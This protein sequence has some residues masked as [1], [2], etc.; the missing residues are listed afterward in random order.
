MARNSNIASALQPN[1]AQYQTTGDANSP[2]PTINA[3]AAR[4]AEA[5]INN[6][7]GAGWSAVGS[8]GQASSNPPGVGSI[9]RGATSLRSGITPIR[10]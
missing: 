2:Q 5:S 3:A 8:P 10:K 4:A 9:P 7:L 1:A 6:C